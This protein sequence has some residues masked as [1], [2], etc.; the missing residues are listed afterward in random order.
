MFADDLFLGVTQHL[1]GSDVP[2]SDEALRAR[3]ENRVV[4]Y[5]FNGFAVD[6]F[7]AAVAIATLGCGDHMLVPAPRFCTASLATKRHERA[8]NAGKNCVQ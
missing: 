6:V 1:L 3:H 7:S 4:P 2:V 8:R 5:V